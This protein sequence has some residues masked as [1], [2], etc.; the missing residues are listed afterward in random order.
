MISPLFLLQTK[1]RGL[2][3]NGDVLRIVCITV[4]VVLVVL[5]SMTVDKS[6]RSDQVDPRTT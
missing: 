5:K 6:L 3:E 2:G 4:E 1:T